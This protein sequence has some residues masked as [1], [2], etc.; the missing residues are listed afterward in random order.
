[1]F[2]LKAQSKTTETQNTAVEPTAPVVEAEASNS[3]VGESSKTVKPENTNTEKTLATVADALSKFGVEMVDVS[4]VIETANAATTGLNEAF[5]ILCQAAEETQV[6]TSVIRE[7]VTTTAMV[8]NASG[9]TMQRSRDAL[10]R[11]SDDIAKLITA[12]SEINN[13]LQGLQG[14]LVS[15]GD[16]SQSIDQIARQTNLLALNATIEAARAGE[17]G[18]G[19]AVVAGEV[20]QLAAETSSATQQIQDTLA[21]LNSEAD[22][23]ISLGEGALTGVSAVQES[24]GALDGVV[25][26]LS[27]AIGEINSSSSIVETGIVDIE[28][29]TQDFVSNVATM[30]ETV[31]RNSETLDSAAERIGKAVDQTDHLVGVTADSDVETSEGLF[32]KMARQAV[33]DVE[34][35]FEA[36][37]DAGRARVDDFFDHN[38][39]PMPGTNPEQLTTTYT[40]ITDRVLPAIQEPV[41]Q[42]DERIVFC[43]AIDVN[44]YLPTHNAK[45]SKPQGD[46]PVWNAANSRN[47]RIF[48]DKVG[49]RAGKNEQPF[50]MQS[51]RRDMGGGQFAIMKDL[52]VPIFIKG[53]HWGGLR[54]AYKT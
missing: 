44:G 15:V 25:N 35:A 51:Y 14:A 53:R 20:K 52:S 3:G 5:G 39:K 26:E 47:R 37:I 46:D 4:G 12:V 49:L 7:A 13:Q 22:A 6:Q 23:L 17:A 24:T 29:A 2:A 40:E 27:E 38:Y 30:Q 1:M 33:A 9:D 32:L 34:A 28:S 18:R 54:L 48:D 31:S 21:E 41:A 16:V 50:L 10:A 36:E 42:S 11:A 45:F 43:A 8:A 19:F